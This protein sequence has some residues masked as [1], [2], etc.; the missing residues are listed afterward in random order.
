MIARSDSRRD[1]RLRSTTL[2]AL[3]AFGLVGCQTG[4]RL[5]GLNPFYSPERTTL[6]TPAQRIAAIRASAAQSTGVDSPEQQAIV[7]K[8]IEPLANE[9]DPLVRQA[10]LEA[11]GAFATPLATR[12]LVA[13]LQ[14]TDA[15]V[16]QTC[17]TQLGRR[18]GQAIIGPL[19]AVARSDDD[20]DVRV[21]ATR[22]LGQTDST[23]KEL[24]ALLK[25]R[26]PAMQ[27]AAVEAM[28]QL[29]GRDLGGDVAA[30]VA[31]A[32]G[33]GPQAPAAVSSEPRVA[34]NRFGWLPFF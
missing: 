34:K 17:C 29:T 16:R 33:R 7:T 10:T 28:R 8:L 4:P 21:A 26:D 24:V 9:P 14:D 23:G 11:T 12:A 6:V 31:L 20:F 19:T 32:E 27:L 22:A 18:S 1:R 2:L 5:A 25:D 13:G 30:Y 3:M 15:H